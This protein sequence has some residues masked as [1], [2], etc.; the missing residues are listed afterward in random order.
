MPH[1][2][3]VE[4]K[5]YRLNVGIVL[6]NRQG[7]I[8]S[9]KRLQPVSPYWQMPQGGVKDGEDLGMAAKRELEEEIGTTQVDCW[10]E[11]KTWHVY[12][13]PTSFLSSPNPLWNG[14]YRGQRQ[15]WFL[16]GFLGKDAHINLHT[17]IPEFMD[18]KWSSPETVIQEAIPFKISIYQAVLK[19][20]LPIICEKMHT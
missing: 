18:W 14:T 4:S 16:F 20:F 11:S 6:V 2:N 8:F 12:D 5:L 19:E 15:R 1:M 9:G 17:P 10:A 13:F 3:D 7:Q